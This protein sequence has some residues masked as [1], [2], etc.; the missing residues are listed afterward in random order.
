[1][2]IAKVSEMLK[3][4]VGSKSYVKYPDFKLYARDYS[5]CLRLN[6]E[7]NKDLI[8]MLNKISKH[9]KIDDISGKHMKFKVKDAWYPLSELSTAE[10]IWMVSYAAR[11]YKSNV[12]FRY[13][14]NQMKQKTLR[15]Y[16]S[17]FKDCEYIT[18]LVDDD[19]DFKVLKEMISDSKVMANFNV[20]DVGERCELYEKLQELHSTTVID[21]IRD[22][23][24]WVD[25]PLNIERMGIANNV[26]WANSVYSRDGRLFINEPLNDV[27]DNLRK[28]LELCC[29]ESEYLILNEPDVFLD[30]SEQKD[31]YNYL[32]KAANTYKGIY[33]S[34][35]V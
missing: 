21:N 12:M 35:Y 11:V 16:I 30:K 4:A 17:E 2:K 33:L 14:F 18:I 7:I 31:F 10:R 8:N 9:K 23:D 3:M 34:E 27:S 28:L 13:G 15:N 20:T 24:M 22:T 5:L 25:V 1:M 26:L 6:D 19:N 32:R 29:K